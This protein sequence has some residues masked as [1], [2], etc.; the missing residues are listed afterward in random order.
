MQVVFVIYD[1]IVLLD[2]AG[3]LQVFAGA[4]RAD[5]KAL[6]YDTAITSCD[7]GRIRSD[8]IVEIDS[9]PFDAWY[10][11][12]IHTL[13]VVGGN[14]ANAAMYHPDIVHGVR[15]L[16][17]QAQRVC[18]VCSGALILGAAGLLK[19]RRATTHWDDC[20]T[21]ER[22]FPDTEV[23][24]DPIYVK[25]GHVWMSAG[26]TAGTDMA[27]AMVAED[28]GPTPA[29]DLA[30]SLLSYMVRP[31]GQSQ[32]SPALQRQARDTAGRFA[33]LHAWISANLTKQLDAETL[34]EQA[35]MS[36]RNFHRVYA[37]T[38]GVTPAKA[39][40][41]IRVERARDLLENTT[42]SVKTICGLCGFGDE[43]RMRRAF[44][45]ETGVS[46]SAYRSRFS[47][48]AV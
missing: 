45:Q 10:G 44:L 26:I 21:L 40:Q 31:G 6:A 15:T 17:R 33:D 18:S 24:L 13:V 39:V 19:G 20:L 22:A 35:H 2:L 37:A 9:E 7:G 28:L 8:T 41:A 38:M 42:D 14:G 46:P 43:E 29:L 12:P 1:N 11:A 36:L 3:P 34:A 27:L 23:E 30:Q 25:D 48:A 16:A 47:L 4:R 5:S 32:F